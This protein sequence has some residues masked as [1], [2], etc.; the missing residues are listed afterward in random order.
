[1]PPVAQIEIQQQIAAVAMPVQ[2]VPK[3]DVTSEDLVDSVAVQELEVTEQPVAEKPAEQIIPPDLKPSPSDVMR[4]LTSDRVLAK[5]VE[6]EVSQDEVT[7]PVVEPTPP[8]VASVPQVYVEAQ[9]S[10][11]KPPLYPKHERRLSREG[12]VTVRVSI[13]VNGSVKGVSVIEGSRYQGFNRAAVQAARKWKFTPATRGG[14]SVASETDIEI[15]FRM[16]DPE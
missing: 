10:D 3:L 5:A 9:R 7:K 11:N 12:K 13:D 15:V 16:T 4:Q 2:V 8:Q 14:V 1:M 6:Q